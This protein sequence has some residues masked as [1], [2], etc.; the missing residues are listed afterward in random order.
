[1]TNLDL[2]DGTVCKNARDYIVYE[3]SRDCPS[4]SIQIPSSKD[5]RSDKTVSLGQKTCLA[6]TGYSNDFWS[7][8]YDGTSSGCVKARKRVIGYNYFI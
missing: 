2:S 3:K 6:L 4:D 5:F 7:G 1:V 8:R